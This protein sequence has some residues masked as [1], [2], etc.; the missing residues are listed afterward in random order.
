MGTKLPPAWEGVWTGLRIL[1]ILKVPI[2]ETDRCFILAL[3]DS[4][5]IDLWEV[6]LGSLFDKETAEDK[7]IKWI[8]ESRSM[9]FKMP[10]DIKRL[11]TACQWYSDLTGQLN[12]SAKFRGNLSQFWTK[13]GR[14]YTDCAK[15]RDCTAPEDGECHTPK[16]FR[17]QSRPRLDIG[18]SSDVEDGQTKMF[19][20]IGYQF[21]V[22]FE[23]EGYAK[24]NVLEI[25]ANL[26]GDDMYGNMTGIGCEEETPN[27][28]CETSC[29]GVEQCE[30]D[31]YSYTI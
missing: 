13:W 22:R 25:T 19:T 26:L 4:N 24:L 31:D 14:T 23:I 6:S 7:R 5:G 28:S 15:Y 17:A 11:E 20:N 9:A 3:N 27:P 8:I 12:V 29:V 10:T 1:R 16:Y 21:Q 30:L 18:K 2:Q